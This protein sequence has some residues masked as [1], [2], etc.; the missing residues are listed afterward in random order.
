MIVTAEQVREL[1]TS[2]DPTVLVA[3]GGV[4]DVWGVGNPNRD[5]IRSDDA[6]DFAEIPW[7]VITS[8]E[9]EELVEDDIDR[10]KDGEFRP[11]AFERIAAVINTS[12]QWA[13]KLEY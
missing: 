8:D 5:K 3:A 13:E 12:P 4:L 1:L 2:Y 10:D 7:D 11:E 6:G 9:V